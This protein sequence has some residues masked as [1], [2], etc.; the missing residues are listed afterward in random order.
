VEIVTD[1][2]LMIRVARV[3]DKTT[4]FGPGWRTAIWVQGCNLACPGCWNKD[5]W[6]KKGGE[7]MPIKKLYERI[8]SNELTEGITLLGGEPLQQA[9]TLLPFLKLI[10]NA[11]KSIFLYTGYELKELDDLQLECIKL[12]DIVVSGRY[13]EEKR[14][15]NLTWRG[16]SNQKVEFLSDRYSSDDM[17]KGVRELEIHIKKDGSIGV[18]GYPDEVNATWFPQ[19]IPDD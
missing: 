8:I 17:G 12:A 14:D 10:K 9:D 13:I 16:S 15:L 4:I 3:L 19:M 11:G 2:E 18:F 5:L 7:D 1:S 6:P